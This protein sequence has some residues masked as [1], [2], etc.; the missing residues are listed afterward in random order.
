MDEKPVAIIIGAGPAGLT[1]GLELL[2][3]TDI[4]PIIIEAEE[5][6]GGISKT[7][8]YKGNRMD[9][10]GHR[11][12]SKSDLVM[13]WWLSILP[14]ENVDGEKIKINYRQQSSFL[15]SKIQ[16]SSNNS[17]DKV[18]LVRKRLSRIYYL[19]KFFSYPV[20][21]NFSTIKNLGIIRLIRI[22]FSYLWVR[23]FPRKNEK[24]LEDFFINRFGKELYKTFFKDY[25]EK[26]WGV[27]CNM[28][29]AEW[30]AQRIK[31]LSVSKAIA[32]A[33]KQ[34]F[35]SNKTLEQKSVETSLIEQF[36]Y[37]KFGPGQL[38]EEVAEQIVALGGKIIFSTQVK[39]VFSNEN[40]IVSLTTYNLK[41]NQSEVYKG[42]YFF[43]TMPVKDLIQGWK[44]LEIPKNVK[45]VADG[46]VYRDFITVGLLLN[47]LAVEKNGSKINDNWIYIQENDVK[48]GRLQIFNNWSPFMVK[49]PNKIWMGL[50][51][52]CNQGDELWNMEDKTFVEFAIEELVKIK[53]INKE[54]VVDSTI[55]RVPKTYPAYFGT[56]S[57]FSEIRKFTDK[58]K[59]LFLVGR[60][61]MHKYNNQDHSMLTAIKAVEL[62]RK[63]SIDKE[64]IW[65]V[66][67]EQ[68]Y[69]EKKQ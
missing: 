66:N 40:K 52:F 10:G 65:Q 14:V 49:D 12:F 61:G 16:S 17:N 62:I 27:K 36:L 23:I 58:F 59:N 51:Y 4:I 11:F 6:V 15:E 44:G 31:G 47:K 8:N 34:I 45:E 33:V 64:E 60:N 26:V 43:S 42:D 25:T 2:K 19:R 53:I 35:S 48:V 5:Q 55:I 37:P 20:S 46:L 50:E 24:S 68:E 18:M 39:E 41:T 1:A 63:K 67:T 38:W 57:E 56:Y 32:H 30:G 3:T 22:F 21:L 69:H 9:L 28:I 29:S 13:D 54:D 7:V